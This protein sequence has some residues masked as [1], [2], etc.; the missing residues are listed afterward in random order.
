MFAFVPRT[1]LGS[2]AVV[3]AKIAAF[4]GSVEMNKS[5]T[6]F[7]L[8]L[9]ALMSADCFAQTRDNKPKTEI[10]PLDQIW[11]W[12]MPGTKNL[13]TLDAVKTGGT[14]EHPIIN[15]IGSVLVRRPIKGEKARPAFVVEGIGK[16]ALQNAQAVFKK[17]NTAADDMPGDT[18]LSLV[19]YSYSSGQWVHLVSIEKF[20]R[21]VTVKY[22]FVCHGAAKIVAIWR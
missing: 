14:T 3:H 12:K 6:I 9:P 7:V 22:R 2:V 18:E 10:I 8:L 15:N 19:F 16:E 13:G 5:L 4:L 17:G 1:V 21:V 11:A 20:E